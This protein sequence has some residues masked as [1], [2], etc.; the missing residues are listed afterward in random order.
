M[1]L[2]E[3]FNLAGENGKL[4]FVDENGQIKGVFLSYQEFRNLG[5]QS[6]SNSQAQMPDV[7]EKI[8]REII[9]AQLNQDMPGANNQNLET[10]PE[11]PVVMPEPV[12]NIIQRRV[13]GL[14]ANKPFGRIE[15]PRY[16]MRQ[17]VMDPN[18]GKPEQTEEIPDSQE[19][20]RTQFDDI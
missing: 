5:G 13:E 4:V 12:S 17:E 8:N 10:I 14:M 20:I 7:A 18:F 9:Q 19:E 3:L 15:E 16:D 2:K 6:P 1:D 11:A